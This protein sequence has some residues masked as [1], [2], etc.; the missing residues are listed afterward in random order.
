M[1]LV[2]VSSQEI[3][4]VVVRNLPRP[5][6]FFTIV[7]GVTPKLR[8]SYFSYSCDS[9]FMEDSVTAP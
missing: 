2:R 1:A 4:F 8:L 9:L 3:S 7:T 6:L 5:A